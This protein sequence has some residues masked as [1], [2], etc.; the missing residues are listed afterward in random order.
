ML[1]ESA[2]EVAGAVRAAA[3]AGVRMVARGSGAGF[4]GGADAVADSIVVSLERM[5]AVIEIGV[6][7]C[8][9]AAQ[10]GVVNDV[11]RATGTPP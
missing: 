6:A 8:L 5:P 7:E 10:A 1:G 3:E 11:L 4:S 9:A 2:E